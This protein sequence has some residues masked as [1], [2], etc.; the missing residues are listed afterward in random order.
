M[1]IL[2]VPHRSG[3]DGKQIAL[4]EDDWKEL[5]ALYTSCTEEERRQIYQEG[6][7]HYYQKTDLGAEYTYS[8]EKREFAVDAWRAVLFFL[9]RRGFV[10]ANCEE[11]IP[12]DA[13]CGEFAARPK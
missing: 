1:M 10:L 2:E 3:E 13:V 7:P 9:H 12:L 11:S 5:F 8:A 4:D 6:S